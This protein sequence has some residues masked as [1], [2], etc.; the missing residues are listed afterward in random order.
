MDFDIAVA[1]VVS[2]HQ[3]DEWEG[4]TVEDGSAAQAGVAGVA[5]YQ[6]KAVCLYLTNSVT[7]AFQCGLQC[8]T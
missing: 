8:V 2:R 7:P 5:Q 6:G 3:I 4:E 1:S